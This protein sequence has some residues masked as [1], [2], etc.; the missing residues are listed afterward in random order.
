MAVPT[1]QRKRKQESKGKTMQTT[2]S[3]SKVVASRSIKT[4]RT[5]VSTNKSAAISKCIGQDRKRNRPVT[6]LHKEEEEDVEMQDHTDEDSDAYSDS[7]DYEMD[8]DTMNDNDDEQE[9]NGLV[10]DVDA[11]ATPADVKRAKNEKGESK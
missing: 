5:R 7:V 6:K 4:P 3:T 8:V 2:K 11:D 1:E 9:D 10:S